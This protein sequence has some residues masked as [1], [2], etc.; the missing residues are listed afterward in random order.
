MISHQRTTTA[1]MNDTLDSIAYRVFGDKS[2]QY[3]PKI[4]TLN[5]TLCPYAILPIGT[6]VVLPKDSDVAPATVLKLWD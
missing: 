4:I 2:N 6:L 3:L 5:P 1:V